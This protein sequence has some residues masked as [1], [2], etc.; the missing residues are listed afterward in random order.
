MFSALVA[1]TLTVDPRAAVVLA[2]RTSVSPADASALLDKVSN[3]VAGPDF[4]PFADSQKRLAALGL[5]DATN[6]NGGADCHVEVA[7]QL[8]VSWLVLVSVSQIGT[9]QSLALEL[10]RVGKAEVV[11]RESLLLARRGDVTPAQ[12]DAF[13]KKVG[14]RIGSSSAEPPKDAPLVKSDPV[15]TPPNTGPDTTVPLTPEP[16]PRSH[17]ASIVVGGLGIAALS[18][19]VGFLVSGLA[20]RGRLSTGVPGSDGLT[21]SEFTG[22]EAQR[23]NDGASVEFGIAGASAAVGAALLTT[24]IAVW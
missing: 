3:A 4:L 20:Q 1:L 16:P 10:F 9:D 22:A 8:K 19:G 21:Y 24:A 23:L 11:E 7:R 5:K 13:V 14:S 2:R 18:V 17:A 12:L 6:C 15:I